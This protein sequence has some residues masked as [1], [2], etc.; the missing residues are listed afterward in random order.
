MLLSPA[1]CFFQYCETVLPIFPIADMPFCGIPPVP[2]IP[3][4]DIVGDTDHLDL[5]REYSLLSDS[6]WYAAFSSQRQLTVVM[7][8]DEGENRGYA[9]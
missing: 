5:I 2:P 9:D 7:E 3:M 8:S 6:Q 4:E 1:I